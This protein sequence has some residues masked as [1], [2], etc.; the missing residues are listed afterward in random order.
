MADTLCMLE[1]LPAQLTSAGVHSAR[2]WIAQ[3]L[4]NTG[5]V[6][7]LVHNV[8]LDPGILRQ[9]GITLGQWL[10]QSPRV[11]A[12]TELRWTTDTQP[13]KRQASFQAGRNAIKQKLK[14]IRAALP[15]K[16]KRRKT[17]KHS[18]AGLH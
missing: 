6:P 8:N 13:T 18:K 7:V 4:W 12:E 17:W 11:M 15:V 9:H 1:G 14:A 3:L 2:A 16:P 10:N 5:S